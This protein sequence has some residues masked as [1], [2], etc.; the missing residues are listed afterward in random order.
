[1]K[2]KEELPDYYNVAI[3]ED[4]PKDLWTVDE[5]RAYILRRIIGSGD[6]RLLNQ[7]KI[8]QLFDVSQQMISKDID[9]I[10][11]AIVQNIDTDKL[12]M[13]IETGFRTLKQNAI[14]TENWD[15]YRKVINDWKS[16]LFEAGMVEK[17]ADKIEHEGIGDFTINLVTKGESGAEDQDE[18]D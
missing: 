14:R 5:R 15:L 8:A 16:W 2:G 3:P 11:K 13:E 4:K 18:S 1:M 12:K 17:E 6:P 10:G 9:Y 7:T